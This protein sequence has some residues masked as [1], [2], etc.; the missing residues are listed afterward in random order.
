MLCLFSGSALVGNLQSGNA[1]VNACNTDLN[2]PTS[3]PPLGHDPASLAWKKSTLDVNA[4]VG[5]GNC[6]SYRRNKL[7][8]ICA[9]T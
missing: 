7:G 2:T 1:V 9:L 6:C 3:L 4:Q 8:Y 5:S